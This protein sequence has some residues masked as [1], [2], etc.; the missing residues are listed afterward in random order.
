MDGSAALNSD[1]WVDND[2]DSLFQSALS[3]ALFGSL[4]AMVA[5]SVASTCSAIGETLTLNNDRYG[6]RP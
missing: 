4:K 6:E 5:G 3:R 2:G 1:M